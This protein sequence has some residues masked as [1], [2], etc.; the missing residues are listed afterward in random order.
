[1]HWIEGRPA[2]G[3]TSFEDVFYWH[4]RGINTRWK[5]NRTDYDH[6]TGDLIEPDQPLARRW[7][8]L[9]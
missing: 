2:F 8:E 6:L 4:F 7:D 1:M 5:D 3:K 9:S